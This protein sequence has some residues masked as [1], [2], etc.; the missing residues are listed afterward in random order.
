MIELGPEIQQHEL[1]GMNRPRRGRRRQVMRIAGVFG[2]RDVRVRVADELRVRKPSRHQLLDVVFRRRHA[3]AD[4]ACDRFERA[5]LDLVELFGSGL[6]RR[7]FRLVPDS[8]EPLNQIAGRDDFD[9]ELPD[10]LHGA[11]IDPRDVRNRARRRILHRDP[12]EAAHQTRETLFELLPLR[13]TARPV[14]AGAPARAVRSRARAPAARRPRESGNTTGAS[15][16]GRP[17]SPRR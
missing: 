1:V 3:V 7:D 14:R 12:P 16:D 4:A 2:R 17:A 10:Q 8:R 9:P 11:G 6:V 13:R 15:P 5:I